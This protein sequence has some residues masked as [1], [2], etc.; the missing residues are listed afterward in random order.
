[1]PI[2]QRLVVQLSRAFVLLALPG[3]LPFQTVPAPTKPP[4]ALATPAKQVKVGGG[5]LQLGD[6]QQAGVNR[7]EFARRTGDLLNADR[8]ASARA[9]VERYPD[10]ALETL[11]LAGAAEGRNGVLQFIAQVHHEQASRTDAATGWPGLLKQRAAQVDSYANYDAHRRTM[12]EKMTKGQAKEAAA[13]RLS[14]PRSAPGQLLT[15]DVQQLEGEAWLLAE[16]PDHS[17]RDFSAALKAGQAAHPYQAVQLLLLR[18][19]AHRRAGNEEQAIA[20]WQAAADLGVALLTQARPVCDPVLWE[21]ISYLR[22][23]KTPWSAE[24]GQALVR[25]DP[26]LIT[27]APASGA[28]TAAVQCI[29]SQLWTSIGNWR[30]ERQEAQAA[31]IAFK[32]AETFSMDNAKR[33]LL[34]LAQAQALTQLNQGGPARAV[35][36]KQADSPIPT[37]A[38]P[39]LA[40]LG[41]L[42]FH[43]GNLQQGLQLLKKA[44]EGTGNADWPGRA[45]AEADLGLAYLSAG[46]EAAGLRWL[47]SAQQRFE[48]AGRHAQLIQALENEAAWF[49][50]NSKPGEALSLKQRVQALESAPLGNS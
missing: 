34:Q 38:Q 4:T 8:T 20:D 32:R 39:A 37:V 27:A 10:V 50:H 11:R 43:E 21:R 3:C 41:A 9:W 46:D 5:G 24:L 7:E 48:Q 33:G 18:S 31:L 49:E 36:A 19:E 2:P 23:V 12:L 6:V 16:R 1:M 22:P 47:R 17:V 45:A 42:K 35:L 13:E 15:L 25:L 14:V 29:E 28:S 26:S 40:M 30:L 44:V